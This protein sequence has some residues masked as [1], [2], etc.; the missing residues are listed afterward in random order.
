MF[1]LFGTLAYKFRLQVKPTP[2]GF[3]GPAAV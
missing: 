2:G 1:M 3:Y